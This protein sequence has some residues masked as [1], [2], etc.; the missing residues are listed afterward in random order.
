[1]MTGQELLLLLPLLLHCRYGIRLV[2]TWSAT[3]CRHHRGCSRSLLVCVCVAL[4]SSSPTTLLRLDLRT[5][6][7]YLL[8][9]SLTSVLL[10]HSHFLTVQYLSP[11]TT[12]IVIPRA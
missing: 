12:V 6:C 11:P 4:S 9:F 3:F 1:M 7:T 2:R 8:A 5:F 10:S